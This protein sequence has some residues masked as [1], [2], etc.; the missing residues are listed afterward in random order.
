MS[1]KGYKNVFHI[2]YWSEMARIAFEEQFDG[3]HL[4]QSN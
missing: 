3:S 1:D 4:G 2:L